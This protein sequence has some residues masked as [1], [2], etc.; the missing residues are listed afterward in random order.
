VTD[1]VQIDQTPGP[2][3]Q[4][5]AAV[6]DAPDVDMQILNELRAIRAAIVALACSDGRFSPADFAPDNFDLPREQEN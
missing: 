5:P 3:K 2:L 1:K 4:V 6:P